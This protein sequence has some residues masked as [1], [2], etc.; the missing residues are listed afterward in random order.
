MAFNK[1][2][3]DEE[4]IIGRFWNSILSGISFIL[5]S[6]S[7]IAIL[8]SIS[9]PRGEDGA[10]QIFGH[11]LRIVQSDSM[12]EHSD[13]DVSAYKIGSFKKNTMVAL[14]LVPEDDAE[15]LKWYSNV[16]VGD[17]LTVRY[18]YDRQVTI[19]H[20]V[21]S[22]ELNDD[23]T[24]YIIGLQGDNL[25]SD[26]G[27]LTQVIDTANENT[28]NFVIGKVIWKSYPLG[29]VVGGLQRVAKAFATDSK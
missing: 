21:T 3:D 28:P 1:R 2:E 10:S 18:A 14:E 20:R 19:T 8:I 13:T 5:I 26:S 12:Q 23:G 7:I 25:N 11:E 24:G 15:A 29:F 6:V 16:A 22:I 4:S 17:V 9:S 27:Q